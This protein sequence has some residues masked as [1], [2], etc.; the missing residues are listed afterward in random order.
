MVNI[1]L[2]PLNIAGPPLR[3]TGDPSARQQ[4]APWIR[5]SGENW[6]P[7]IP[8]ATLSTRSS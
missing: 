4:A 5:P 8:P 1:G 2:L 3:P 6:M 7:F